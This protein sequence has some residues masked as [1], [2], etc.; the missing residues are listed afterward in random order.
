[1]WEIIFK[2]LTKVQIIDY[3]QDFFKLYEG[4]LEQR[5]RKNIQFINFAS[6]D[7]YFIMNPDKMDRFDVMVFCSYYS[8]YDFRTNSCQSNPEGFLNIEL[9]VEN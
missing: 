5:G 3:S 2:D 1:M 6:N 8:Y 9:P 4:I 7:Q